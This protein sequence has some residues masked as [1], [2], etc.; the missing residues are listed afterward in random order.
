MSR[1]RL[2][3]AAVAA[4]ALAGLA[5]GLL[6]TRGSGAAPVRPGVLARGSFVSGSWSTRGQAAIARQSDGSM[7]LRIRRLQTQPAA[8]LY[9]VLEANGTR[10]TVS[11][12]RSATGDQEYDLPAAVAKNPAQT[13]VIY[14]AKCNKD[15]GSARLTLTPLGR[16]SS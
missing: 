16:Q 9:V 3:V 5:V 7:K 6:A 1:R 15:W 13:V 11:E 8:E 2:S 4:V 12:L 14:C 10:Q